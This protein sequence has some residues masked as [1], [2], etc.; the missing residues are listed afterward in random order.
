MADHYLA[1][2]AQLKIVTGLQ[3]RTESATRYEMIARHG[4]EEAPAASRP[5]A[6]VEARLRVAG[7]RI[8]GPQS[9]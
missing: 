2:P 4:E 8:P 5:A 6:L 7:V 9:R 3:A 1:G